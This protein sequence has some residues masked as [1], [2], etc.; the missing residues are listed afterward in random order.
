MTKPIEMITLWVAVVGNK[1]GVN[2]YVAVSEE[3]LR[4]EIFEYVKSLWQDELGNLPLP[5]DRDEAIETY[6]EKVKSETCTID[7]TALSGDLGDLF[8]PLPASKA[9]SEYLEIGE[10]DPVTDGYPWEGYI[11]LLLGPDGQVWAKVG[12]LANIPEQDE[13]GEE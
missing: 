3:V 2:S 4:D 5:K 8:R 1:Y 9:H 12:D 6:F 11:D 10:W 7:S 13:N